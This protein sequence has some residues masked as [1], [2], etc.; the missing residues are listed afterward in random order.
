MSTEAIVVMGVSGCGKSTVAERLASTLGWEFAEGDDFHSGANVEKMRRGEPLSDEDRWPWLRS[1][2]AHLQARQQA[3]HS[4]VVTC[5]ALRRPYRDV[6]RAIDAPVRFAHVEP[7]PDV[8]RERM[9]L[10]KGHY[11]PA[12]LLQSQLDTLE[13]LTPDEPGVVVRAD[14]SADEVVRAVMTALGLHQS[15]GP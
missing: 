13:P 5:S 9:A 4:V 1:I 2:A 7:S 14:R 3:G 6:L 8:L 11:M 15:S 10:R 12:S